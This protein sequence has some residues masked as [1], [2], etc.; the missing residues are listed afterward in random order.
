MVFGD[1]SDDLA[2]FEDQAFFIAARTVERTVPDGQLK[3]APYEPGKVFSIQ[4]LTH[5]KIASRHFI[6]KVAV[7]HPSAFRFNL[8]G[9]H[10][11]Y[12]GYSIHHVYLGDCSLSLTS[13]FE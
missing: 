4:M 2:F 7:R 3:I 9:I 10:C 1:L 13:G 12:S 5:A 11:A 8:R 6:I